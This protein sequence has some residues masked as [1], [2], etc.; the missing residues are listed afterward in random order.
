M[1]NEPCASEH[2]WQA[3]SEEQVKTL[4]SQAKTGR[5]P[6]AW[7]ESAEQCGRCGSLEAKVSWFGHLHRAA[8]ELK[9]DGSVVVRWPGPRELRAITG[10]G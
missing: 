3:W 5:P 9:P 8:V 2:D 7:L 1:T 10:M 4:R 6:G